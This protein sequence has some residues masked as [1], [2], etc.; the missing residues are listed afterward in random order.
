MARA[1]G[2]GLRPEGG[3]GCTAGLGRGGTSDPAP[4]FMPGGRGS[5]RTLRGRDGRGIGAP[6]VETCPDGAG[7]SRSSGDGAA[8]DG[9]A[10]LPVAGPSFA[11]S[12]SAKGAPP[13]APSRDAIS[14]SSWATATS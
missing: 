14:V 9:P 12:G 8:G 10:G 5:R 7:P 6:G 13:P 1:A 3:V 11:S 4:G 2:A